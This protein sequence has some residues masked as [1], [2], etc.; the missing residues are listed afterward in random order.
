MDKNNT[1][2][3]N[4]NTPPKTPSDNPFSV[5]GG[6]VISPSEAEEYGAFKRQ[7][8]VEEVKAAFSKSEIS[9][10]GEPIAVLKRT[11][12]SVKRM[13]VTAVKVAPNAVRAAKSLLSTSGK[14]IKIDALIGGMGETTTK[15]KAYEAKCA[16]RDGADELTL[17]LSK[18]T[19][20]GG[21]PIEVK[22]EIAKVV[23]AAK[24]LPVKVLLPT[25]S[26]E[27][28]VRLAREISASGAAY[29]S[30]P[31]FHGCE[32]LKAELS[33]T[34]KLE[35]TGVATAA[36]FKILVHAG[37]ERICIDGKESAE[38]IYA[39]LIDE[40]ENRNFSTPVFAPFIA[41]DDREKAYQ[42]FSGVALASAPFGVG[43]VVARTKRQSSDDKNAH[44]QESERKK[45]E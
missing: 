19:A 32:K 42:G 37:V 28:S 35:I 17:I 33:E 26:H 23:K 6:I 15:V 2:Q 44:L 34:C 4:Q 8:R 1:L 22:R 25:A 18:S 11:A 43:A 10:I 40:A 38:E 27:Q 36:D 30:A 20:L 45:Q 24:S 39:C 5:N 31:Y 3:N 41:E 12:E 29:V 13:G 14:T 16:R 21:R 7:K 9:A